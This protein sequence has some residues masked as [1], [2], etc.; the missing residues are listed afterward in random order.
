MIFFFKKK[1]LLCVNKILS[2]V[3][4]S[5][6]PFIKLGVISSVSPGT[7]QAI[8]KSAD[9]PADG[10]NGRCDRSLHEKGAQLYIPPKGR[11]R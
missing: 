7:W 11:V 5:A 2:I 3:S 10:R 1:I 8:L 4:S 9:F 6:A